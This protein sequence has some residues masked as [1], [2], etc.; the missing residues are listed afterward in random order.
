ML[1][2][3]SSPTHTTRPSLSES[4]YSV[5]V[6]NITAPFEFRGMAPHGTDFGRPLGYAR[7]LKRVKSGFASISLQSLVMGC[8]TSD[9]LGQSIRVEGRG[10]EPTESECG[11]GAARTRLGTAAGRSEERRVGEEG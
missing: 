2:I 9:S 4:R 8:G 5:P 6:R 1:S 7:I 11:P 3:N 10:R